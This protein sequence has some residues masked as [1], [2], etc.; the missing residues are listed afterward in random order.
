ML[1]ADGWAQATGLP[2]D[3]VKGACAISGLYGLEPIRL[4]YL[5]AILRLD[6]DEA[7]RNSPVRLPPRRQ[8]KLILAVGDEESDE[9]L[10][11]QAEFAARWS[12]AGAD[13]RTV[14]MPGHHHFAVVSA[15][16]LP[17]HPLFE[18]TLAMV[19]GA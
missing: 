17:G 19:R 3:I 15:L 9:Y 4:S 11:Q 2:A 18:A 10:R 6:R 14:A 13:I 5:N 7:A 12:A 8:A 16:A 1:L